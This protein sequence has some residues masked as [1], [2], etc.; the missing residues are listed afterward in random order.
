MEKRERAGHAQYPYSN[1][2]TEYIRPAL[3][4]QILQLVVLR[5]GILR[6][7]D[8]TEHTRG[9]APLDWNWGYG[10][11]AAL[12]LLTAILRGFQP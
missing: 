1:S 8:P 6:R 2:M 7:F 10:N 12:Y 5:H 11:V 3:N 4:S 9:V